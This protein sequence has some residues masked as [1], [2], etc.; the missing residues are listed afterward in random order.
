VARRRRL[1]LLH[2]A[3]FLVALLLS[4]VI[5]MVQPALGSSR[6]SYPPVPWWPDAR[7]CVGLRQ[8]SPRL[9]AAQMQRITDQLLTTEKGNIQGGSSCPGGPVVV[10]LQP[11]REWL[12]RRLQATYGP[13]LAIFIGLTTWDGR[14]G[15]SPVCGSLPQPTA[16]PKGVRLSLHLD[17]TSVS[18][19]SDFRGTLLIREVGPARFSMATGQ[20]VQAVVVL[21]GTQKVVAVYSGVIAGTGYLVNLVRGESQAVPVIGGTARCDGGIGSALPAGTY[22]VTAEISTEGNG[23]ALDYLTPQAPLRVLEA[24]PSGVRPV[25]PARADRLDAIGEVEYPFGELSVANNGTLFYVDRGHGQIDLV[26]ARGPRAVLSSLDGTAAPHGSIPGLSGLSVTNNAIWFTAGDSLYQASLSGRDVRRD[27]SVPGAVDLNALNDGTTF[28]TTRTAI[29]ERGS[30]GPTERVAGGSSTDF[31]QQQAGPQRAV[32]EEIYPASIV[33][34]SPHAFYF[35]NENNLY[36]VDNGVATMLKPR[37]EFFNGELA[38]GPGGSIYGICN[39]WVCRVAGRGFTKVFKLPEPVNGAFAAPD[40][41]AVSPSGSFY[42][43][44]SDQSSQAKAGIVELS[45]KGKVVA[46]VA[47]RS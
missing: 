1:Q 29:F 4:C 5:V 10:S 39:W 15:R 37:F 6:S 19:G 3:A 28:F 30:G 20:P 34:V 17:G 18:S 7:G 12:A 21:R 13:K 47:S 11:G 2:R 40:A 36:F 16:L 8:P 33:G 31:V 26:T 44:Y 35:T 42:I 46:I 27:G 23:P 22:G 25:H 38:S 41:F 43:S 24:P 45:P 32:D 14:P 9:T